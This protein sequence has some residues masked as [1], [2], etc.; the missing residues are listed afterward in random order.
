MSDDDD[1]IACVVFNKCL[2]YIIMIS[3]RRL[4]VIQNTVGATNTFM[5]PEAR[6]EKS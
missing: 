3:P 2:L 1:Y 6:K 5:P 4:C